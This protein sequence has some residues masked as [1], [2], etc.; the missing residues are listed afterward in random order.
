MHNRQIGSL[1]NSLPRTVGKFY[2]TQ[3]LN[4]PEER[5]QSSNKDG[6]IMRNRSKSVGRIY[7][8][9]FSKGKEVVLQEPARV[10]Y[11]RL[12]NY[13]EVENKLSSYMESTI[14]TST[15]QKY[16]YLSTQFSNKYETLAK[17]YSA[18][19]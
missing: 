16:N 8:T 2:Q 5:L 1:T 7:T 6:Q 3:K 10:G 18:S 11:D 14:R 17:E 12:I 13:R 15:R 19:Y 9:H 4:L